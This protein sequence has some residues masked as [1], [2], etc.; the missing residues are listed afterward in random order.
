MTSKRDLVLALLR[1]QPD[2]TDKAIAIRAGH[3]SHLTMLNRRVPS[4]K[5]IN[6]IRSA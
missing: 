2:L 6:G 5:R 4:I 3:I 1:S